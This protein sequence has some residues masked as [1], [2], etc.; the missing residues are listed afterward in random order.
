MASLENLTVNVELRISKLYKFL[1]NRK[2]TWIF[3][4]LP[5]KW[6]YWCLYKNLM[7]NVNDKGFERMNFKSF[8]STI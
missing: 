3:M 1:I 8:M 5:K 4:L 6:V 7:I 2:I